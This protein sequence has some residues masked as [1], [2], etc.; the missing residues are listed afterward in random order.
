MELTYTTQ[1]TAELTPID[2]VAEAPTLEAQ[3][4]ALETEHEELLLEHGALEKELNKEMAE[5]AETAQKLNYVERILVALFELEMG[6]SSDYAL[7]Q[8]HEMN[9]EAGLV[10]SAV[11]AARDRIQIGDAREAAR[12]KALPAPE[13]QS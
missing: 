4:Q 6:S 9:P 8:W 11:R 13:A 7:A 3:F 2:P 1:E 10:V 5:H 12:K